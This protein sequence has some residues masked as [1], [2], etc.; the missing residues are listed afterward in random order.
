ME[1]GG[2]SGGGYRRYKGL[3]VGIESQSSLAG[4]GVY[5]EGRLEEWKRPPIEHLLHIVYSL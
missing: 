2:V 1:G 3:E 4:A 5:R